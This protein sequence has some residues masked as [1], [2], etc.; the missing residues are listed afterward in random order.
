MRSAHRLAAL[1]TTALLVAAP[2]LADQTALKAVNCTPLG[3][4]RGDAT[5]GAALHL[6]H[7]AE[8]HG[9]DGKAE[10]IVMHMDVPPRDQSDAAYMK[11]LPDAYLYLA[12]CRGGL[13]VGKNFIMPAWGDLLTDQDIKDLVA[14]IRTFSGT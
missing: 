2:A 11:T 1:A 13:G 4:V 3:E 7:C 12:I 9:A 6:K 10:V 14:Q 8:C 5:R